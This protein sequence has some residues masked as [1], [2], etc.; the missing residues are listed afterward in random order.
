MPFSPFGKF[1]SEKLGKFLDEMWSDDR[2]L[3]KELGAGQDPTGNQLLLGQSRDE[4]HREI[5]SYEREPLGEFV[6]AHLGHEDIHDNR[7]NGLGFVL[8]NLQTF[9]AVVGDN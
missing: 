4:Y 1:D 8:A 2:L 7:P 5:G 9:A 3:E 6:A